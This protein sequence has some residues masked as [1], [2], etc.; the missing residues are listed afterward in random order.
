M[1]TEL[2]PGVARFFDP[3]AIAAN[4]AG[5]LAPTQ[6]ARL[7]RTVVLRV[8]GY[9]VSGSLAF[10]L[11]TV[12]AEATGTAGLVL[13]VVVFAVL[14]VVLLVFQVLPPLLDVV[15]G[16]AAAVS[17]TVRKESWISTGGLSRNR[18]YQIQV[19]DQAFRV[20]RGLF[21]AVSGD[22]GATAYFLPRTGE[23]L[24]VEEPQ[25]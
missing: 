19:A 3:A 15:S 24:T 8:I 23:L 16:R 14:A 2:P 10:M 9:V 21:A 12:R 4:R 18:R 7:L 6:A 22:A 20:G 5:R 17:G 13:G 1:T 25:P 11:Y